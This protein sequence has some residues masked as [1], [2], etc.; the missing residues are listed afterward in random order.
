MRVIHSALL[1]IAVMLLSTGVAAQSNTPWLG[2]GLQVVDQADAKKMGIEG[3]LKVTRVDDKSPAKE[4]GLEVGDVILSAGQTTITSIESMRTALADKRAGDILSLGV[5][6]A[7]GKNE[8]LI[9]TLAA[10]PVKDD[11]FGDD[12]KVKELR[13]KLA[14][15]DLERRRTAQE[16]ERR[17]EDLRN[18]KANP[19]TSP[20]PVQPRVENPPQ[21]ERPEPKVIEPERTTLGVTLNASFVNLTPEDSKKLGIEGGVKATSVVAQGAA[22]EGGLKEDDII[23]K[24]NGEA[25]TGTGHMRTLLGKMK[26]GDKLELEVI[27]AGK[28]Q[29][30]TVVLRPRN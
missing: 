23:S 6:R 24:A 15:L 17:L 20:Q 21:P 19:E 10:Q 12:A 14:E 13:K 8:P 25:V 3:G 2:C 28:K 16:L 22:A 7:N 5:R 18:G 9:V 26:A 4:A 11:K 30:L 1:V 29:T 27:R